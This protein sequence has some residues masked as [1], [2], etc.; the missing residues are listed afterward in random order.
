MDNLY[1]SLPLKLIKGERK[2]STKQKSVETALL[3]PS[4]RKML[5]NRKLMQQEIGFQE[6]A[7]CN[8]N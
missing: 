4:L 1:V 6:V 5:D 7:Q 8:L 2:N 3:K